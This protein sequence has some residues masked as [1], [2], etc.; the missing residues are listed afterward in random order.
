MNK[1]AVIGVIIGVCLLSLVMALVA[2][3]SGGEFQTG[4]DAIGVIY[5]EGTI[6]GGKDN[7]GLFESSA[8]S[9][10]I[11][12]QLR[13]AG[14]DS[15]LKAIILRINSPGGSV[16]ASQEIGE[17]VDRLRKSGKKIVVSMGDVAASGGYWIAA[18]ADKIVA[19]PGTL[20]GSIGV[21]M[22]SMEY[23]GLYNK[24]GVTDQ[25]IKSGAHKDIGSSSRPLTP[26]ERSI[27]QTMVNDMYNQFVDVVATGRKLPRKEVLKIADGR[28][29]TG[30]QAKAL[31]LVDSLGNYY[32]A[33]SLAAKMGGIK[34]EPKI[35][36]L[37]SEDPWSK[38]LGKAK[39]D[40]FTYVRYNQLLP[41]YRLWDNAASQGV[42]PDLNAA[43]KGD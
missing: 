14:K 35:V 43:A 42:I 13:Q 8:A 32:D 40:L 23:S 29:L 2:K 10:T 36:E 6:V 22:E 18:K 19:N 30:Q 11:M 1:K 3:P 33:V 16:G 31:G 38:I 37:G 20:T 27:L 39:T 28:V 41:T 7:G 26:E 12:D 25:T 17:E 24:L 4:T 9:E 5:I 21:I 15:S 34:G